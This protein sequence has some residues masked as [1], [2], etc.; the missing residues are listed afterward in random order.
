MS[1]GSA[2]R[3]FA[4]WSQIENTPNYDRIAINLYKFGKAHPH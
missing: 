2:A 1:Y 4:Y 3:A